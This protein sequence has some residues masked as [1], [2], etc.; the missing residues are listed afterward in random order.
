MPTPNMGRLAE[1]LNGDDTELQAYAPDPATQAQADAAKTTVEVAQALCEGYADRVALRWCPD[2]ATGPDFTEQM[3][4]K[5]M[6]RR[7][8]TMARALHG[9]NWLRKK[10]FVAVC[11]FASPGWV[12]LDFTAMYLGA[13]VVPLPLNVPFADLTYMLDETAAR[14][15]FCSLEEVAT[16]VTN[17]LSKD[18]ACPK[19]ET[20]VVMDCG[21]DAKGRAMVEAIRPSLP[22]SIQRV[23]TVEEL[24]AAADQISA[25]LPPA[26]PG[27]PGWEDEPN[28]LLGLMYTSGS[29]GRPKGAMYTEKLQHMLLNVGFAWSKGEIPVVSLCFLPLNHIVGRVTIYQTVSKGGVVYFVRKSDMSTLYEDLAAARPTKTMMVPRIANMAFETY[30]LK[31][32]ELLQAAGLDDEGND[33]NGGEERQQRM[34]AVDAEARTFIRDKVFGGRLLF[35]IVGSAPTSDEVLAFLR[36]SLQVPMVEGYGTTELG[37]V[38]LENHVNKATVLRWKLID[39]PELG[40]SLRDQPYPRGELLV[41]TTTAIPGYYKHPVATAALI[42][43]EG[44]F[45]TGDIMEQRGSEELVWIDRRNNVLKLAQG[46]FV[47]VSRLEALFS[48]H[49]DM[50]NIYLYG[51]SVRSYILG[52]VVPSDGLIDAAQANGASSEE[53]MAQHLKPVLRRSL[54]AVAKEAGLA[55]YEVPRDFIVSVEAFSRENNLLTDSN[56]LARA[57]LKA[58]FG[59]RLEEMYAAVEERKQKRLESLQHN[60][61]ASVTDQVRAALEMTL[62]VGEDVGMDATFAQLGGDSLSAVRVTE[63]IKSLCGVSVPVAELLNPAATLA[64]LIQ[65]LEAAKLGHGNGDG[66]DAV[67]RR[68]HGAEEAVEVIHATALT[69]DKFVPAEELLPEGT[70]V[71]WAKAR[72]PAAVHNVLLTGG[73]GFLGRF[74]LLDLVAKVDGQV[75]C[76]VRAR[77]DAAAKARLWDA[78]GAHLLDPHQARIVVLAGDVA[79]P[80]LGL[81]E[82]GYASLAATVDLVLHAGALVNHNLSYQE[83]FGPNVLGTVH[84]MRF[85]LT[86]PTKPKPLHFVSTVAVAMGQGGPGPHVTEAHL[87]SQ[88]GT[89]RHIGAGAYAEGYGASKWAAEVLLQDLHAQTGLPVAAYR[90]SMILPHTSLP[91]QINTADVFTRLLAGVIYTGLAPASF[92]DGKGAAPFYDGSPVDF[93]AGA[94]VAIACATQGGNGEE[95]GCRLFHVVNPHVEDGASLDDV[96][97]WVKSAG[98]PVDGVAPYQ[99]WFEAFKTKLQALAPDKRNQSP[100]PVIHQWSHPLP[101]KDEQAKLLVLDATRFVKAVRALT[102]WPDVPQLSEGYLHTCLY[103]MSVLDLIAATPAV[104]KAAV[105]E[106]GGTH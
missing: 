34:A 22:A 12:L 39:V 75:Y 85:C 16:L 79:Q 23:L 25:P 54:D 101:S 99:A 15:V 43:E 36:E 94:I 50:A 60:P 56:K 64:S 48:G 28:P 89:Q 19:V 1:L 49:A 31:R 62:G 3:T 32:A 37:G 20:L 9:H 40:Y 67:Y 81:T 105:G 82:E 17:V 5:E 87:G 103:H 46:E 58:V 47:S 91:G 21:T 96:V 59:P 76:L 84:I 102:T 68:V 53:E 80:R 10:D 97:A 106:S 73:N 63:H 71:G 98:Y 14:V 24:L 51:N 92:T 45:H 33:G 66:E 6:W 70:T 78:V 41:V 52:V 55:S 90:C 86:P 27:G 88:W 44:L 7:V 18:G 57:R 13:V 30:Q 42:D 2:D 29:T 93:V 35:S 11:G 38:T 8:Q 69:L 65:H 72:V 74:L 4:Y 100:L 104:K 77:D 61:H 83:L 26:I 95:E